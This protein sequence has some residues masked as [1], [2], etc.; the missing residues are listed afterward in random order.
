MNIVV[1]GA[2]RGLG[3]V[4]SRMLAER[5]HKVAAGLRSMDERKG[6]ENLLYLP[7]DV[8]KEHEI[9]QA[10]DSVKKWMGEVDIVIN[11]AGVLLPSDRTETLL[12]ESLD[13]IRKQMEVN[14]LG[15]ITVFREFL[16]IIKKGGQFLAVTS[17]GGSFASAG[18]L[19]P[20]Y[21]VSKTAANKI[22]QILRMTVGDD[23]DVVAIHPGRMNT[24]MGRTT[25]QIEPEVAA[26]GFCQLIEGKIKVNY[27]EQ[28]F[29]DYLGRPMPL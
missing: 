4:L 28:W 27:K 25:A 18:S 9:K 16:P 29:I 8:M 11:V 1:V 2:G 15:I 21:G 10:V 20:A 6:N 26:E 12:T 22:V 5:G 24:D 23:I 3:D 19:F 14:A 17:E 13:D 7:M